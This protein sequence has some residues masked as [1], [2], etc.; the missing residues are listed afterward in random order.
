MKR[1]FAFAAFGCALSALAYAAPEHFNIDSPH[2]AASFEIEHLGITTISGRFDKVSGKI[3]LDRAAKTGSIE[4]EMDAATINTGFAARDKLLRSEDYFHTEKFPTLTYRATKLNFKDDALVSADGELT[5]LGVTKPVS[6]Q[7]TTFK[8]I[9]HP[10]N[11]RDICGAVARTTIKRADFGM[12][13]A[14][15][16]L[17]EEVR[18][19]INLE[20]IKS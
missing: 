18:I 5:M 7:L 13:R 6:L 3:T 1:Q 20:A 14:S 11:K 17:G 16:S 19:T 8:C 15:R 10:V 12:T 4:A 9:V 2:S